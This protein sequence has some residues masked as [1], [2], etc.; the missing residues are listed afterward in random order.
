MQKLTTN[1]TESQ[2]LERNIG[3]IK[4]LRLAIE[5]EPEG[6]RKDSLVAELTRRESEI[7]ALKERLAKVL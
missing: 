2:K 1:P 3:R 5:M 4:T 7:Q 6:D